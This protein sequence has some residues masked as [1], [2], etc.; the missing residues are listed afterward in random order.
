MVRI[1]RPALRTEHQR[2]LRVLTVLLDVP[3]PADTG[4]ALRHLAILKLIRQLGCESHALVFTNAS[5]PR[6]PDELSD[7][8]DGFLTAGPRVEYGA[9]STLARFSLRARMIGPAISGRPSPVYPFSVQYDLIS[10]IE[11]IA[12]ATN[13]IG[14]DVVVLPT[15]LLHVAPTLT[16]AGVLVIGD[17]IDVVSQL[18]RRFLQYGKSK[19]WRIPGLLVNHLATRSQE[20]LFLSACTEIWA[21]TDEEAAVL[22]KMTPTANVLVAGNALDERVVKSSDIPQEGPIGFIGN[23]SLAPNLNAAR[24]LVEQIFPHI[25]RRRPGTRLALAGT[26]MPVDIG[27][28]FERI[29]GVEVLGRVDDS[30]TFIRSSR[31]MVLPIRVR[32]GLPLKLV[33]ALACGRPVVATRELVRGLPLREGV[34]VLIGDDAETLA[35][36]VCNVLDHAN[37][38]QSLAKNGRRRFEEEFSFQATIRR[39]ENQ[40]VLVASR[41]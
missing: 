37:V 28:R 14:A 12:E 20:S 33:E 32:G 27:A 30:V 23:Y 31:V 2:P 1:D 13:K 39:L 26:G 7:Y 38:A 16:N 9:L 5:R 15:M 10:A 40:S 17:A 29:P 6:I 19:P 4:L 8:C 25:E 24:F 41:R 3:I 18:T 22:R 35:S 34:D 36:A 21:T 11:L